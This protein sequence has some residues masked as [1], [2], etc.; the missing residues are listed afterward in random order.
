MSTATSSTG[1]GAPRFPQFRRLAAEGEAELVTGRPEL[2]APTIEEAL[3]W[4]ARASAI[5][6]TSLRSTGDRP[7]GRAARAHW[8][9]LIEAKMAL[10]GHAEVVRR[11]EARLE[12]PYRERL[13]AQPDARLVP[14]GPPGGRAAGLSGRSRGAGRGA[15]HRA[16][17][18]PARPR[19]RDLRPGPG[20]GTAY[21]GAR[22]G[23]GSST[24][25]AP[26][27]LPEAGA[28]PRSARRR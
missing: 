10:G 18:A 3:S 2:A 17:G 27:S 6:P 5:S 9:L 20:P 23:R 24:A 7:S 19:T 13:R 14:L 15:G 8:E 28:P 1:P 12:N 25:A 21:S 22:G 11:L 16:G 4:L 26:R